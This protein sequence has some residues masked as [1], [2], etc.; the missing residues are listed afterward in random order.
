MI[1]GLEPLAVSDWHPRDSQLAASA[2]GPIWVQFSADAD[3]TKAEQAFS[4]S[5]NST[6]VTGSFSWNGSRLTFTP[7]GAVQDGNDYELV[8][9]QSAETANGNSLRKDFR[10]AFTTKTERVRPA[11]ASVQPA[12]GSRV[13]NGLQP[14]V[15]Q[16][17]EPVDPTSL[18]AA[19]SISPDPGGSIVVAGSAATFTPLSQ[20]QPGTEYSI[21]VSDALKDLSGNHL[22]A[23]LRT[24]FTAGADDI[25]PNLAAVHRVVNGS[26]EALVLLPGSATAPITGFEATMGL[27][28]VFDKDVQRQNIESFIDI[29]PAWG[30]QVDAAGAPRTS[31]TLT[32]T[33]RLD[34]GTKYRLTIKHGVLDPSGNATVSDSTYYF[35]VDGTATKPP[36]VKAVRFN[37]CAA[38]LVPFGNLD[39]SAFGPMEAAA[40]FDVYFSLSSGSQVDPFSL[41]RS[42]TVTATNGAALL[43]PIGVEV[44]AFSGSPPPADPDPSLRRQGSS[45]RF[46][47]R[48]TPVW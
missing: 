20:W 10:F 19:W 2:V 7:D 5:E 13:S 33:E 41:M 48:R 8:V 28:I 21:T 16:F 35:R 46:P 29:E 17:S 18:L 30:F 34:W 9:L 15:I 23:P 43:T 24:R 1:L 37:G 3:R 36:V 12:D 39:L 31:F 40:Y 44:G 27:Q 32:P 22:A 4:L 14:V 45:S 38:A 25:R 26:P 47:T 42:F 11:V 6:A